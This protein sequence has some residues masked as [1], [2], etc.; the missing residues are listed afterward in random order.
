MQTRT[1]GAT[2]VAL[3]ALCLG[4]MR[5]DPKRL[6]VTEGAALI[7]AAYDHGVTTW[8]SSSEYD[9]HAHFCEALRVFRR[10]HPGRAL[11]HISKIAAPHF[12]DAGFDAATLRS[13]VEIQLRELGTERLD[14]VQWLAR[15]K[16]IQD[17]LRLP[18]LDAMREQLAYEV[19]A[20]QREGKVGAW[21]AFPYSVPWANAFTTHTV[22]DG[23][24][25]YLNLAELEY[26]T[27]LD[28]MQ[29]RGDG[30]VAIRPLMAGLF[31]GASH[32]AAQQQRRDE[33]A[34]RM[35]VTSAAL[36][37]EALRFPLLHPN[38]ASVI[39]SV[40]TVAHLRE[41]VEAVGEVVP[42]RERFLATTEALQSA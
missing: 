37:R 5:F 41:A 30:F 32:D 11:V 8:H 33:I 19:T 10:E 34:Q 36:T 23:L 26:A 21:A 9:T 15:T 14:V 16:P 29:A 31:G 38:V 24:V 3:S 35:G 2:D 22:C 12:E 7:D 6:S 13:R 1:F 25:T 27:A 20:L 40:T 39:V 4:A 18:A 42:D 17:T 28:D